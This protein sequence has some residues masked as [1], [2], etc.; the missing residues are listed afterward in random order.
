[1]DFE[2]GGQAAIYRMMDAFGFTTRQALCNELGVSKSTMASRF[3]RDIFPADWVIQCALKTGADLKWLTSG[4]GRMFDNEVIDTL[5]VPKMKLSEGTTHPAGYVMFDKVMLN[6]SL[7]KPGVLVEGPKSYIVD[8]ANEDLAD[9]VWLVDIDGSSSVRKIQR[10]PGQKI[11]VSN[12]EI[13]FDCGI[14]DLK[15]LAKVDTVFQQV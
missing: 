10:L 6:V 3:M 11:R 1:M 7:K 5:K 9:G 13:T 14:L 4:E 15:L 12:D 8:F 2:K